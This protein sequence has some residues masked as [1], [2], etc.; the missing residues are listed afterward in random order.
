MVIKALIFDFD[1][2]ILDTEVPV[3][4]SWRELFQSYGYNLTLHDWQICIGS[5]EGTTSFFNSLA[6]RLD[7][8]LDLETE[9]PKRLQRELEMIAGQPIMPGVKDYIQRATEM[10][11]KLGV[12]SSSPCKWVLGHLEQ[13]ELREHFDCILAADDVGVTKPDPTLYLTALD[14]LGVNANQAIAFEDSPNGVLAAR[15]AGLYCVAVP[16]S[17]TSQLQI[18]HADLQLG[19]LEDLAL[20]DLLEMVNREIAA[21]R[22]GQEKSPHAVTTREQTRG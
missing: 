15:R 13:R 8:P 3:Y 7:R 19:S 12:A 4:Q 1:G 10:G 18:K 20:D 14:C 21:R 22:T 11:L 17:L 6:D 5:A 2:L 9:A 16:N